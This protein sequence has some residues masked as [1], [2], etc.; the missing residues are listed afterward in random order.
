VRQTVV[1]RMF[2]GLTSRW[3]MDRECKNASAARS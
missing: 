2:S 3:Q 1:S